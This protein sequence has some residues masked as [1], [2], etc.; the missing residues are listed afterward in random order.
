MTWTVGECSYLAVGEPTAL[1]KDDETGAVWVAVLDA[2]GYPGDWATLD[3][4]SAGE[5][6]DLRWLG[7]VIVVSPDGA[8]LFATG[9]QK[10]SGAGGGAASFDLTY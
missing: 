1:T 7:S 8:H 4:P 6:Y 9:W 10:G 5:G 2:D 3:L